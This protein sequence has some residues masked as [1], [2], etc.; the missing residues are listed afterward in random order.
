MRHCMLEEGGK[1]ILKDTE[2]E[3][4]QAQFLAVAGA[5]ILL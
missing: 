2:T 4:R 1:Q 5:Y 3:T